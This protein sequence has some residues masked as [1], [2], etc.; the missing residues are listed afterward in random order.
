MQTDS[1]F[2]AFAA[3]LGYNS[4]TQI[5]YDFSKQIIIGEQIK[6]QNSIK[7]DIKL[8]TIGGF[9]AHKSL[10]LLI[11]KGE[12]MFTFEISHKRAPSLKLC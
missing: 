3:V 6:M 12:K 10:V 1:S 8:K 9:V 2:R 5:I 7:I 4:I 11:P